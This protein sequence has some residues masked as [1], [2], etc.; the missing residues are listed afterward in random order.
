MRQRTS[1]GM[2]AVIVVAMAAGCGKPG[3]GGPPQMAVPVVGV[4]A[5][6]QSVA[7]TLSLVGSMEA[8]EVVE[9]K[10]EIDGTVEDIQ[11]EEGQ[12]VTAGQPLV[13]IDAH[14][15][16][17]TLAKA[18]ADLT[19]AQATRQ[20]YEQLVQA[21]AV[22]R[23]ELDQVVATFGANKATVDLMKEELR[24]ASIDAPFEGVIGARLISVGQFVS[25]GA[26][27]TWLIDPDPMK[28][29]F[30]VPERYIGQIRVDQPIQLATAAYPDQRFEG[31]IYFI[32]PQVDEATRTVLV[33][34]RL[35]NTDGRLRRGM[36]V[37]LKLTVGAREQA[38]V[39]P[40]TALIFQGDLVSV[41]VV[42]QAQT[43][44]PR[45]VT[46]GER[47]PGMVEITSGVAAGDVVIIEGT[48]KLRPG[49][50]AAVRLVEPTPQGA[51]QSGEP[52]PASKKPEAS[53]PR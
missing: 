5:L 10:S 30:H 23:Q 49:A 12:A 8:N 48:Q 53:S 11:F 36:F 3:G 7:Q 16:R 25:R 51:S 2:W 41:Y 1:A 45:Q 27:L 32:D 22:S 43:V 14:K 21:G 26:S 18:E 6:T 52:A 29:E 9:I 4:K 31:R 46:V 24:E 33:K 40:E 42:D 39:V 37:D 20:R 17:A 44:Q 38:I 19:L 34:A 50:K 28:A 35:P 13:Q 47:M 15:L